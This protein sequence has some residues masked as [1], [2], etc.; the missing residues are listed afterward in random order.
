VS[1]RLPAKSEGNGLDVGDVN[2]DGLPDIVVGNSGIAGQNFLWI[3]NPDQPGH[4]MDR[5]ATHPPQV[6]D[7]TQSVK[8]ADLD[9]DGDLDRVIGNEVPPNRLLLNDG[10]G[11]FSEYS[12]RLN[13]RVSL[14]TREVFT[15]DV[16]GDGDL[17]IVF[18]NLTSN[19]GK[20]DKDPRTRLLIN[21][22]HANFSDET[23]AR[24][25]QNEFSTYAAAPMDFDRDGHPDLLLSAMKIPPFEAL[26]VHA[27]RND[28]K[29]NFT[30]VTTDVIPEIT[31][32]RSWGIS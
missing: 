21:D 9:G 22:G 23:E 11:R 8:L 31:V 3:N 17:D 16:E 20:R 26:Q 24:L 18:A 28:G 14:H 4:F 2:G 10:E 32:G 27:Y 25:P 5:S 30:D 1:D 19:G 6:T 12:D 29:G 13:L 15:V 7:Q